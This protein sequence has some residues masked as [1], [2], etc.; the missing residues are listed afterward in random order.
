[1]KKL[2]D[3]VIDIKITAPPGANAAKVSALLAAFGVIV[4]SGDVAKFD[5]LGEFLLALEKEV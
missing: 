5:R 4:E 2:K 3:Y 1:M